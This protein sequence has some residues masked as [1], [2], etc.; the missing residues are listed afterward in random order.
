MAGE[1]PKKFVENSSCKL[2]P[3]WLLAQTGYFP[4]TIGFGE[5]EL[6]QKIRSA[7]PIRQDIAY[8]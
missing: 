4:N 1:P 3:P 7:L 2:G 5:G 6:P 8:K